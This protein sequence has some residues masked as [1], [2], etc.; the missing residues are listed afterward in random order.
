MR[1]LDAQSR[2]H[3]RVLGR[4]IAFLVLIG[5]PA[6]LVDRHPPVLYFLQLQRMFGLLAL[7]LL[8]LGVVTRQPLARASLCVW[9]HAAASMLLAIG[10]SL[11]LSFRLHQ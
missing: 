6:L 9:D 1:P 3:L 5:L 4:Q 2:W 10:C 11:I 7:V 8:A